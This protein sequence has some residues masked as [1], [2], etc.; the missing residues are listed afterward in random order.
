VLIFSYVDTRTIRLSSY[1][2]SSNLSS[3]TK[4]FV[5]LKEQQKPQKKKIWLLKKIS[6]S[7]LKQ[8]K[9]FEL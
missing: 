7:L 1:D 3:T 9:F 2:E 6:L 8:K 4:V 5:A